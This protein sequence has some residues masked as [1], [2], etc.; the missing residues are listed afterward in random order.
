MQSIL[1]NC[2]LKLPNVFFLIMITT[3]NTVEYAICA[4]LNGGGKFFVQVVVLSL[5]AIYSVLPWRITMVASFCVLNNFKQH[6]KI[7][8]TDASAVENVFTE[9]D[10]HVETI[11]VSFVFKA[12]K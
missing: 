7:D 2:F 8:L 11:N 1:G 4:L 6:N 5:Y 3:C 9:M 10:N 12:T